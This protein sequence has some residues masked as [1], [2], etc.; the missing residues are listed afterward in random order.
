[1]KMLCN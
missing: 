1:M